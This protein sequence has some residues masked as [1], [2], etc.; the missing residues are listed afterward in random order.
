MNVKYLGGRWLGPTLF[1]VLVFLLGSLLLDGRSRVE[2]QTG[3]GIVEVAFTGTL[4]S[5]DGLPIADHYQRVSLNV[6][7]VRL[8][9]SRDTTISDSDPSWVDIPAPAAVGSTF[10]SEFI[11]TS[12]NFGST[13]PL[14]T[15]AGSV[16]QLDLLPLQNL[17]FFFNAASIPAQPY[18][19]MEVVLNDF[20]PGNA[21]PLCHQHSFGEG[22][23]TYTTLLSQASGLRVLF[24]FPFY[25]VAADVVQPLIVN[26]NVNVGPP[27]TGD[28]NSQTVALSPIITPQGAPLPG[29]IT[30]YNPTI[31]LVTGK[32]TNFDVNTTSV[33]AEF[34]GTDQIVATTK[35]QGDGSYALSLP[36]VAT[37]TLYDFYVSGKSGGYVVKS[38][39]L[40]KPGDAVTFNPT[41]PFSTFGQ[42]SGTIADSC[43]G[44]PIEAATLKLLVADTSNGGATSCD[45]TSEPAVPSPVPASLGQQTTAP[46][47][48]PS[49]CVVVA[50]AASN[51]Q[52]IYPFLYTPFTNVA[53]DPPPGVVHYD[54]EISAPGYNTTV[55]P[56]APGSVFCPASRFANSC[57][58]SLEHGYLTG[59][60]DLSVPNLTGNR[61]NALV[62]AED[63]GTNNIENLTLSTI[64]GGTSSG[65]F[66]MPVPIAEPSADAIPVNSLDVFA[67]MQDSFQG[68]PQ[69]TTGHLIGTAANVG[70]PSANCSTLP[71]P[72]LSPLNCA[73]LGSVTGTVANADPGTTS[74]R[75]SKNGVQIMQTDPNEI[76][77][78]PDNVYNFCAP[79]DLYTVTHYEG[80]TP[81]LSVPVPSSSGSAS[82]ALMAPVSIGEPC[83]SICQNASNVCLVCQPTT[84]PNLQ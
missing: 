58:F 74:V 31:G 16:L 36:A 76:G 61:L 69:K 2:S 28:P 45:L 82:V 5:S 10:P 22:C 51:D 38:G 39:V 20:N 68:L 71:I 1:G 11:T 83:S 3:T 55:V 70:A 33:S 63:S 56:I 8:N 78:A 40:V 7:S 15:A 60:T 77:A 21:V 18:G 53:V 57:S 26:I 73:G 25:G 72:A 84:G 43:N 47:H 35:L 19:Q 17:P 79:T 46:P 65:P 14:L 23:I 48:P 27:P 4:T 44:A 49:N 34:S 52:G 41:V 50:T 62:M 13:G 59:A 6:V 30:P 54:L 24:G 67:S 42:L 64:Q 75:L 37:G 29:T 80:P 12:L 66:T 32:V 81:Q 9:P